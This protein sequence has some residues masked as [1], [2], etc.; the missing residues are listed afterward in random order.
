[1][2]YER[3]ISSLD[4][5]WKWEPYPLNYNP[6]LEECISF[7]TPAIEISIPLESINT[8]DYEIQRSPRRIQNIDAMRISLQNLPKS[9]N[10]ENPN[11]KDNDRIT[12]L[13]NSAP[14]LEIKN[15]NKTKGVQEESI[16]QNKKA[17][18][19]IL[20]KNKITPLINSDPNPESKNTKRL[21]SFSDENKEKLAKQDAIS[22][23]SFRDPIL[24]SRRE[25]KIEQVVEQVPLNFLESLKPLHGINAKIF[26]NGAV[27]HINKK[28]K[29]WKKNNPLESECN[30]LK[31]NQIAERIMKDE[32]FGL[33][34]VKKNQTC[35]SWLASN[36]H[37]TSQ[38]V[39]IVQY[40]LIPI[41]PI[42]KRLKVLYSSLY[43]YMATPKEKVSTVFTECLFKTLQN[44][45]DI[46][47][48]EALLKGKHIDD[49]LWINRKSKKIQ[50]VSIKCLEN[51]ENWVKICVRNN[52]TEAF[53]DSKKI[54]NEVFNILEDW[55]NPSAKIEQIKG[56][57]REWTFKS[58]DMHNIFN[59]VH[60]W[61]EA[62]YYEDKPKIILGTNEIE[63]EPIDKIK[64]YQII[65]SYISEGIVQPNR[66]AI[67]GKVIFDVKKNTKRIENPEEF[68][69]KIFKELYKAFGYDLEDE[70]DKTVTLKGE[71]RHMLLACNDKYNGAN[72]TPKTIHCLRLLAMGC[73]KSWERA[74]CYFALR[75]ERIFNEKDLNAL[76]FLDG[77]ECNFLIKN[78]ND[79]NAQLIKCCA[80]ISNSTKEKLFF[81]VSWN[82]SSPLENRWSFNLK[83]L[84]FLNKET[85]QTETIETLLKYMIDFSQNSTIQKFFLKDT[86][87]KDTILIDYFLKTPSQKSLKSNKSITQEIKI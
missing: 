77:V 17:N 8:E 3:F 38:L 1:M 56:I 71:V 55:N 34:E 32:I 83:I 35:E 75:F 58:I 23:L 69:L 86:V 13:I 40:S 81:P 16:S 14:N 84:Q 22:Q 65:K 10:K 25:K 43:G 12:R 64:I 48:K 73:F 15:N 62:T 60:T 29:E 67:N 27:E 79:Y 49:Y 53:G 52:V 46:E 5:E 36:S 63:F 33:T 72:F 31:L 45:T 51:V 28:F 54:R 39:E 19:R 85:V 80:V 61:E 59:I 26:D 47:G 50:N 74:E 2:N 68:M 37:R 78:V 11:S 82:V 7:N 70:S 4:N 57:V 44:L 9:N 21:N 42:Y 6:P 66:I 76:G 20:K 30:A 87:L 18:Q 24:T 41:S